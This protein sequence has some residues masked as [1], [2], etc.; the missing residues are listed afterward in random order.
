MLSA[1]CDLPAG[2]KLCG[3]LSFNAHYGCTRCWK[4]FPGEIGNRDYSGFDRESW[5]P[6]SV[7]QHRDTAAQLLEC[8]TMSAQAQLESQ[9]GY[10]NTAL[11]YFNPCRMLVLDAMHNLF[12]G[13]AKHVLKSIWLDQD[14]LSPTDFNIVQSKMDKVKVPSDIGRIP[15]KIA[16]GFSSFTAD[17]FKNWVIYFSLLTLRDKLIGDH[18]ECWRHFVLACRL[19]CSKFI[20]KSDVHLAD[21]LLLQC[22]RRMQ[23]MYGYNIITP[24]MHLHA[25]LCDCVVDYGPLH[26]FWL[27]SFERFN[28][29]LGQQPNNNRSIEVQLMNRFIRDCHQVSTPL[30]QEYENEFAPIFS[31][32]HTV[33]TLSE[34]VEVSYPFPIP[35]VSI[36]NTNWTLESTSNIALPS[37]CSRGLFGSEEIEGLRK[38]YSRLYNVQ[39][40]QIEMSRGFQKYKTIHLNGKKIGCDKSR[41]TN[42]SIVMCWWNSIL[43]NNFEDAR[44][45]E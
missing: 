38:L 23:R 30:P 16:S 26:G 27:F 12:L 33:G 44:Q 35:P 10:R 29:I 32:K 39:S 37:H 43:D 15:Y 14:I 5:L 8:N 31:Y 6:R 22:C 28:G 36:E 9:T 42:S 24:N 13:T 17:Q 25:H 45:I 41:S 7:E 11:P 19:L 2:R 20:T 3:F 21:A 4:E 40:S 34:S 1:A 18:L